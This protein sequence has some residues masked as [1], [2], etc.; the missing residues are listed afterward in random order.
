MKK[1]LILG[2]TGFVGGA[3]V[4]KLTETFAIHGVRLVVPSRRPHRAKHLLTLPTVQLVQADVHDEARLALLLR[5]CDAVINLVA[6][7]HG[8]PAEFERTHVTL[9]KKLAAACLGAGVRRVLH[10][11]AIGAAAH[12][13]SNY[14][15]SKSAG[16]AALRSAGLDLS[17]LRPSVIFGAGDRFLN[18]FAK[19]QAVFPVMPLA[20]ADA[21]FQPVWV[22]DVA[23]ALVTCLASP[24]SSVRT[25][26]CCGPKVYTLAELVRLAGR[27]SG[28]ERPIVRLS[29]GLARAQASVMR[30]LPGEPLMS[31]DNL[32][33]MKQPSVASGALPGL[34]ALGIEPTALEAVAP[35]YLA[36]ASGRARM[37]AW[38]SA[39][40]RG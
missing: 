1:I 28:H 24:L 22:E 10:V 32:E 29:D 14:L 39:A 18:L 40:R 16:E 25:Y 19:L 13:P 35:A 8:T 9:A 31:A 11:S 36:P 17:V 33:S 23:Q 3:L 30:L 34:A 21:R 37:E 26:E 20:G 38:R 2:G 5:D 7:L 4:E 12:A 6:I 27:W 15:R